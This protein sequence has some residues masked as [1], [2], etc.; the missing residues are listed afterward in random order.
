MTRT[1]FRVVANDPPTRRDFMSH[2]VFGIPLRNPDD[3]DLWQGISVQATEQQARR[4][5]RLPG[6][7]G[8]IAEVVVVDGGPIAW[9]RTGRQP[10]HH[11]LWGTPDDLLASVVRTVPV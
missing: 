9:R 8:H 4:R 6:F 2:E 10:G 5:A 3:R 1:F 11:T 7:G